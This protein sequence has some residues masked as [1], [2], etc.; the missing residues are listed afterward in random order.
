MK[1]FLALM[2]AGIAVLGTCMV[3]S[4]APD[5]D[6]V[7]GNSISENSVASADSGDDGD[8]DT[9]SEAFALE[10]AAT[11][12][13][14]DV[15]FAAEGEGKT[16]GEYI[17]NSVV[18]V[19]GLDEVTPV[20]Q[21]GKIVLDG[22][23]SNVNFAVQKPLPAHVTAAKAQAASLGGSVLNVVNIQ[24]NVSFGKASV[25][26]YMP[27]VKAGQKIQVYQYVKGQWAS[28]DVA[29]IRDDHVTVDMTSLGVFAFI[30][31]Q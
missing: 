11:G 5:S 17:S 30:Q 1:R 2:A 12:V 31:V 20:G 25:N 23:A 14:S 19:P 7:S 29:E 15:Y 10:I 16:I 8:Y 3:V 13:S 6:S 18:E 22:K 24:A 27:G 26:F 9:G 21:G 28:V 4:A